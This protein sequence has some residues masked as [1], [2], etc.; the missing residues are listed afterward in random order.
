MG[1]VD[2][3]TFDNQL[4]FNSYIRT[5]LNTDMGTKEKR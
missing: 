5:V 1:Y 2:N 3:I 4:N